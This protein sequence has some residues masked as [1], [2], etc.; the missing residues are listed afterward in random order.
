MMDKNSTIQ[1]KIVWAGLDL[2]QIYFIVQL[3]NSVRL[4]KTDDV[5]YISK[6]LE[7]IG[8]DS[9]SFLSLHTELYD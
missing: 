8:I 1:K 9:S 7:L 2:Q 3:R 4:G 6:Q 5:K